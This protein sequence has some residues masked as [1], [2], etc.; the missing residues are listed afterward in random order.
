MTS[1]PHTDDQFQQDIR[2]IHELVHAVLSNN[3]SF[4][5]ILEKSGDEDKRQF[6]DSFLQSI[7]IPV[8]DESRLG[9][10]N[11]LINLQEESFIQILK[12]NELPEQEIENIREK[13]YLWASEHHLNEHKKLLDS[14]IAR[15]LLTPF[16][17]A[18]LNGIHQVGIAMTAWHLKWQRHIIFTIN[19]ALQQQYNDDDSQV[20]A[21]LEEKS[22]FDLGHGGVRAE[23]SYS[24]L[25]EKDG[26]YVRTAYAEAFPNE[27]QAVVASLHDFKD[28]LTNFEDPLYHQKESYIAYINSLITAFSETDPD[29]LVIQWA[30]VD[31]KWMEITAPLQPGH[32]LE[33]YED[34]YRMAVA[35][36]WDLRLQEP[37]TD[38]GELL[39]DIHHMVEHY[40]KNIADDSYASIYRTFQENLHRVQLYISKPIL[41]YGSEFNGLFS[42][43]VVPNDEVISGELGKKIFAF[44]HRVLASL[45][46]K[47]FLKLHAEIF[48]KTF[49]NE[50]KT[51]LFKKQPSWHEVYR[52]TTIGHEYGHI[53]W[54]DEETEMTMN[55]Q[56]MFKNIEEFKA[57]T[58]GLCAYFV[59]DS[60]PDLREV[61]IEHIKRSVGLIAWM[62]HNDALPYYCESLIHLTGLF[63][64]QILYF[65]GEKVVVDLKEE[66]MQAIQSWYLQTY[67]KLI[68]EFYLPKKDASG[69]LFQ[70][71]TKEE[72]HF[73]PTHAETRLFVDHYWKRYQAIGQ[74]IDENDSP[75]NWLER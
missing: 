37:G 52:I 38:A 6:I 4:Y 51:L 59:R 57:T 58:G 16:Y 74:V 53:L 62:E 28:S 5:S 1:K 69:F 20:Y 36:E 32:P 7:G 72:G 75:A 17:Q 55:Q 30:D 60:Q 22:L 10:I 49:Q 18:V 48:E 66:T 61:L 43:Q 64:S 19:K 68:Q 35:P 63:E 25:V 73:L 3:N 13:A 56:G 54:M 11:R 41:Y 47:P 31:R 44:P 40:I 50:F 71:A 42:A 39:K 26:Q 15:N 65:D 9:A 67:Q 33:Y 23:R 70:Y 46:A 12:K 34:K 2:H 24:A 21:M 8:N 14:I 45:Q 29:R 27:I